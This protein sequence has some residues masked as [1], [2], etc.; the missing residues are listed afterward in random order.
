MNNWILGYFKLQL[1][2]SMEPR[3][4]ISSLG[5]HCCTLFKFQFTCDTKLANMVEW[6]DARKISGEWNKIHIPISW[7]TDFSTLIKANSYV[8]SL[9]G[10]FWLATSKILKLPSREWTFRVSGLYMARCIR[11]SK[12]KETFQEAVFAGHLFC[13]IPLKECQ[14]GQFFFLEN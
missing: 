10:V 3:L 7:L 11:I 13:P 1:L 4:T 2:F 8:D 12:S 5:M 14:L 9:S 6:M